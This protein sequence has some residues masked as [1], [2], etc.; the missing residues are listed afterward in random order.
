MQKMKSSLSAG[1][2][3]LVA[4]MFGALF[5]GAMKATAVEPAKPPT[6]VQATAY[7]VLPGTH[8]N[9]SG[10]FSLCEGLDGNIYIGTAKYGEN[11]YLVE[12][13][14]R[15][16]KQRIV[17]DTNKLCDLSAKGYAAQAKIHTRNFVAPSGKIYVG[18]KQGYRQEGDK[19]EYPG[20]YVMVYDPRTGQAQNLG[21]PFKGQGVID[22]TADEE[23]G[24]L[25]VVTCEDQH[26]MLGDVKGGAYRE[27]GPMLTPYA[28]TLL[29]AKGGACVITKDFE[30]A[31]YDP[32][33]RKIETRP[34]ELDGK[35]FVRADGN[36]IPAWV[37]DGDRRHAYAILL[38]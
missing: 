17:I 26:W 32:A 10:Y 25:Y 2:C 5:I 30:L 7:H 3:S 16:E 28:A 4:C 15:T 27:L 24:L 22:V 1:R 23:R 13:D 18:S 29:D 34:I 36:S 14:P 12:F 35:R 20:G 21:M 6:Y 33:T 31:R 19:A 11:S 8:N 37:L 38:N 9:E